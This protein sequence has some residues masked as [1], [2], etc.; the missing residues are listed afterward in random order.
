VFVLGNYLHNF[1]DFSGKVPNFIEIIKSCVN[2]I[3]SQ[4]II[5][6]SS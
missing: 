4:N 2:T 3:Q 6:L 1:N 5:I